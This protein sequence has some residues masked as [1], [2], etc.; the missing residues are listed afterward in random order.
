MNPRTCHFRDPPLVEFVL[1]VRVYD[2]QT[3]ILELPTLHDGC[4]L[5]CVHKL[6]VLRSKPYH[7]VFTFI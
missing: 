1:L 6:V 7:Q 2:V 5:Q 4:L 3:D